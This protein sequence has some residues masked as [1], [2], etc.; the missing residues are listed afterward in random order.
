[1]KRWLIIIVIAVLIYLGWRY[2]HPKGG[3]GHS[4]ASESPELILD[5]VWVDS[6]PERYT[7]YLHAFIILDDAPIGAFQKASSYRSLFEIFEYS[8]DKNQVRVVFPQTETKRKFTYEVTR[9]DDLPP[10]DLC[11]TFSKNPWNGPRRYYSFSDDGGAAGSIGL[12]D[13]LERARQRMNE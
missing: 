5:R 8:R 9:C 4:S 6:K 10:F 11:L 7:D 1:M 3:D 12:R 2:L 13:R